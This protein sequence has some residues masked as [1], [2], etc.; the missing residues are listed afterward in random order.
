VG[1]NVVG[2]RRRGIQPEAIPA[3]REVYRLVLRSGLPRQEALALARSDYGGFAE[4][5]RFL[6]FFAV[7][8]RGIARHGRE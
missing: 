8:K 6:D 1:L 3:L 5:L 7:S 4:C 2:L